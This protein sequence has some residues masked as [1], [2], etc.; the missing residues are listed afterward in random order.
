MG[1]M[2]RMVLGSGD[3]SGG[4]PP[5]A[6]SRRARPLGRVLPASAIATVGAVAA[7]AALG[8]G[9][10]GAAGPDAAAARTV[11][12]NESGNLHKTSKHGF[13]LNEQGSASGTIR[14]T[15]FIH[16]N[17]SSPT[18]VSA[19][20]NIYPSGGSLT[21]LGSASYHVVGSY[22]SFSGSLS[23]SR[24]TGTYARARASG[25]SFTGTVQ[26]RNDAVT[27]RLSGPLSY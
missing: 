16:L 18:R 8:S 19:E 24:G 5:R 22:A 1:Q 4:S 23:I 17:L 26:R 14:G 7:F 2:A 27:V 13:T 25:L 11:S 9:A 20:V 10:A 3:V 6:R 15:I 12:L 21:G